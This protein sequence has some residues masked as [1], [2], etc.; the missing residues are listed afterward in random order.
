MECVTKWGVKG[1]RR[2]KRG[3]RREYETQTMG[4]RRQHAVEQHAAYK[5]MGNESRGVK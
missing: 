5:H 2:L 1:M 4:A 3:A